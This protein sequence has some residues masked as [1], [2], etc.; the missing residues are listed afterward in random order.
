[1]LALL[2]FATYC[3]QLT[4]SPVFASNPVASESV[5]NDFK[6]QVP[7]PGLSITQD[8]FN[9]G[10]AIGIYI[11]KIY[12][13]LVVFAMIA[14]VLAFIYAGVLWLTARG[15]SGQVGESKKILINSI[16]GVVLILGSYTLL[17]AVNPDLVTFKPLQQIYG[18]TTSLSLGFTKPEPLIKINPDGTT[19]TSAPNSGVCCY[20]YEKNNGGVGLYN[21]TEYFGEAS[22]GDQESCRQFSMTSSSITYRAWCP[23]PANGDA[24]CGQKIGGNN[25]RKNQWSI[26]SITC[27]GKIS[28]P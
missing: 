3:L 18:T 4:A 6:F 22:P 12:N 27:S 8:Q 24:A 20:N 26:G 23:P 2:L 14:A 15:D 9:S 19:T 28:P 25:E 10:D 21:V 1:Y 11:T 16:V 17:W 13:W 7:F 5:F